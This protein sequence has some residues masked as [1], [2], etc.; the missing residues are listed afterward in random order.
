MQYMTLAEF[1]PNSRMEIASLTKIMTCL[2]IL[3]IAERFKIDLKQAYTKVGHKA[4][5]LQG[6]TAKLSYAD[7]V[8][9]GDLLYG[10][11]L[12]S[13]NDAAQTLAEWGGKTI[14]FFCNKQTIKSSPRKTKLIRKGDLFKRTSIGLF[15]YHM[16]ILA[17]ALSM[18]NS[19]FA[20]AHGLINKKNYSCSSDVTKLCVYAMQRLDFRGIV[21]RK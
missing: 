6:T 19:R 9:V 16:N 5:S 7:Y 3:K 13:G 12:P 4:A 21:S 18:K 1:N 8:C 14:R 17:K 20:N 11:M 2:L 10:M 15:I